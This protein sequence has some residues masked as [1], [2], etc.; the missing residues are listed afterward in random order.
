MTFQF[1]MKTRP[2]CLRRFNPEHL[3]YEAG[4]FTEYTNLG[5]GYEKEDKR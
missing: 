5:W 2:I 3:Y 1:S 4:L